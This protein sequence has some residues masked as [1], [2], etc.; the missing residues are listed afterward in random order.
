MIFDHDAHGQDA[1]AALSAL[2]QG[3]DSVADYANE[4]RILAA[5]C[6]WNESALYS[7]FRR[8]LGETTKDALSGREA[9]DSLNRLISQ[10]IALDE[11]A[12]ERKRERAHHQLGPVAT[13]TVKPPPPPPPVQYHPVPVVAGP[14]GSTGE[15]PMQLGR[16]RTGRITSSEHAHRRREGLCMFCASPAHTIAYCPAASARPFR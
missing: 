12:R 7:A 8:G 9:P 11:R 4:F 16:A 6:G 13:T 15:E 1:A 3:S 5:R 10:A 2:Q 14:S